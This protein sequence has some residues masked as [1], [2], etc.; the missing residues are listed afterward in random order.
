MKNLLTLV[1]FAM[2]AG[3]LLAGGFQL[4]D[5]SARSVG[6]GFNTAWRGVDASTVFYNP[7]GMTQLPGGV[8][9]TGGASF[10]AP[11]AKYTGV[12][13]YNEFNTTELEDEVFVV[14]HFYGVWHDEESDFALGLGVFVPFGLGTEWPEGWVGEALALRASLET[15]AINPN[16]AYEMF[17]DKLSVSVGAVWATSTVLLRQRIVSFE[18][19]PTLELEGDD[20]TFSFN[21]GATWQPSEDWYIGA[22]YRHNLEF[23]YEGESSFVNDPGLDP[24]FQ[25]GPGGTTINLP[26]DLRVGV[27]WQVTPELAIAAGVDFVGWSSYD[28]LSVN[29]EKA[30]G[31]PST[32]LTLDSPRN[33]E[34]SFIYQLSAE[35]QLTETSSLRGGVYYDAVPVD[36]MYTQ[37]I[38]PDADRYGFSLGYGVSLVD[39][40]T[41]DIG[42]LF[43]IGAQREVENSPVNFDGIYNAWANVGS[44]GFNYTF[45]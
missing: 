42:A 39:G 32:S 22:S 25:A 12:A 44:I 17:D 6:M 41:M 18:P 38:L 31:N 3:P 26:F 5:N 10:I 19:R 4:N 34:D 35:Y 24:L 21:V 7:A 43:I 37:P 45:Q 11:G 20:Q 16:I 23:E 33:Y 13:N 27:G 36:A 40:L 2:S 30:P 28:T 8:H 14:P 1:L 9:L 29:F 15:I